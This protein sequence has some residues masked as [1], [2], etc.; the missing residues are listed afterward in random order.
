[1]NIKEIVIKAISAT[2][3]TVA[4]LTMIH[5]LMQSEWMTA[6]DDSDILSWI[7]EEKKNN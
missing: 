1:M 5:N 6:I 4:A 3:S 7:E 2:T